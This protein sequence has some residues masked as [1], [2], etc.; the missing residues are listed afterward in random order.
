MPNLPPRNSDAGEA[1]TGFLSRASRHARGYTKRWYKVTK[2]FLV[3]YPLCGDRPG[4]RAPVMSRCRDEGRIV[5]AGQVDHVVP[6]KGD[7]VL[8]WDEE[9]NWQALCASCGGRKSRAGL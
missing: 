6:H 8:F 2:I 3:K 4:G 1:S 9:N 5:A 7:P